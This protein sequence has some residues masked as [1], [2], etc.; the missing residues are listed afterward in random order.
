[1]LDI[2]YVVFHDMFLLVG[3]AVETSLSCWS[4]L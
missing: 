4:K 2:F 1:M 3:I